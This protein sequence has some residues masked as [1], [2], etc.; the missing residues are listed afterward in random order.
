MKD[1]VCL[2]VRT[3]G[4]ED[5]N[6]GPENI[7]IVAYQE[8]AQQKLFQVAQMGDKIYEVIGYSL[9]SR[10]GGYEIFTLRANNIIS[11]I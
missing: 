10:D 1:F 5:P 8:V 6:I 9:P 3:D 4:L 7:L 2:V 11:E